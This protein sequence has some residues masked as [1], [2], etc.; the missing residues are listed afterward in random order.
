M[1]K[2]SIT[3]T[4]D[5]ILALR[6]AALPRLVDIEQHGYAEEFEGE[7]AALRKAGNKLERLVRDAAE[8]D[9]PFGKRDMFGDQRR[10]ASGP[11]DFRGEDFPTF[12][13]SKKE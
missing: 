5:E 10:F 2:H 13:A 4:D 11:E 12:T 3:L 1:S 8:R 7:G 9:D 6:N